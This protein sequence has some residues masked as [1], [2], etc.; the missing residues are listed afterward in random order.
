MGFLPSNFQNLMLTRLIAQ[1]QRQLTSNISD[2]RLAKKQ[3]SQV[4]K[5]ITQELRYNQNFARAN[6]QQTIANGQ[7][8]IFAKLGIT[9]LSGADASVSAMYSQELSALQTQAQSELN[10]SLMMAEQNAEIMREMQVQ[11][12]TDLASDLEVEKEKLEGDIKMYQSWK[13]GAKE[14]VQSSAKNLKPNYGSGG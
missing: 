4:E 5:A 13:E 8:S 7:Q 11:P 3:S 6:Y 1:T 2:T 9:T 12:L 14:D 10:A